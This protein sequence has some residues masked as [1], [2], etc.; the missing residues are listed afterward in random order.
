MVGSN[1]HA[2]QAAV[3]EAAQLG[4]HS[5]LLS[6][7][8]EGE[9]REVAKV[10]AALAR[11]IDHSGRPLPRPACI[12]AGGETTVPVRG[13]GLGRRSQELALA[14]A[15]LLAGLDDVALIALGTDGTDGPTDA[16]GAVATGRTIHRAQQKGLSDASYLA[17]NDAYHF[18]Q[19]LGDLII[20]GPTNT[21][22]NDLILIFA[23]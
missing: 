12:V 22:V 13:Q 6:T 15:P 20:T 7:F 8:I 1:G 11:E 18:F 16:A 5:Q 23:F 3:D 17:N 4:L 10:M 19:A 9:A 14:A 2:A 21:N